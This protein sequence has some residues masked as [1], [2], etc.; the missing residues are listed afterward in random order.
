MVNDGL[1]RGEAGT[2]HLQSVDRLA[3]LLNAEPTVGIRGEVPAVALDALGEA[4]RS[5]KPELFKERSGRHA[6]SAVT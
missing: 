6:R 1:S 4:P 5:S 3:S 2:Q